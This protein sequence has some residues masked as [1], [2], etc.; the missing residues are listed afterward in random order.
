MSG[1]SEDIECPKCGG[2][3]HKFTDSG[4]IEGNYGFCMECG[5]SYYTGEEQLT[6]EAVNHNRKECGLLPLTELEPW[7]CNKLNVSMVRE[8]LKDYINETGKCTLIDLYNYVN[9]H[10]TKV[11]TIKDINWDN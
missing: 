4:D 8:L 9:T 3:F 7:E 6:L 5:Y 1:F 2:L 11:Y 10:D